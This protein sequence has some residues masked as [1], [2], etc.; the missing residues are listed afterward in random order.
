MRRLGFGHVSCLLKAL[1]RLEQVL[2]Q[3]GSAN[4]QAQP[5]DQAAAFDDRAARLPEPTP[6]ARTGLDD[7]QCEPQRAPLW[8]DL[9]H[10]FSVQPA[11]RD[12][13]RA[14]PESR[15]GLLLNRQH[16][17]RDGAGGHK[18]RQRHRDGSLASAHRVFAHE[19]AV[20]S[21]QD[22]QHEER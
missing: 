3:I 18:C 15:C 11:L 2:R 10:G 8:V 6:L 14:V 5:L 20:A 19:R 1:A 17:Q 22:H 16:G 12:H 13:I 9:A 4:V 7:A 21:E